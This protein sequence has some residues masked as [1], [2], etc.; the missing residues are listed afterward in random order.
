M[1]NHIRMKEHL[2]VPHIPI[3]I[4]TGQIIDMTFQH[5]SM[6][7][8]NY[9]VITSGIDMNRHINMRNKVN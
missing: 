8:I 7:N 1:F 9:P 3:L 5:F 2:I 6:F 4:K